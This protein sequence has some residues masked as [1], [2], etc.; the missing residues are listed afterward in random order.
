[1]VIFGS[2]TRLYRNKV[3]NVHRKLEEVQVHG[4][5]WDFFGTNKQKT[6]NL[7]DTLKGQSNLPWFLGGDLNEILDREEKD[8]GRRRLRGP[9]G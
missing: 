4:T 2:E 7:I 3:D 5:V 8:G 6:W 9:H 1:M